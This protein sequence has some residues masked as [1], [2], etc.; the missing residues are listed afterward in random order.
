[1][2]PCPLI[3][4][5]RKGQVKDPGRGRAD[6]SALS[7]TLLPAASLVAWRGPCPGGTATPQN[8]PSIPQQHHPWLAREDQRSS[9]PGQEGDQR[10]QESHDLPQATLQHPVDRETL[11]LLGSPPPPPPLPLLPSFSFLSISPHLL[12]LPCHA[13]CLLVSLSLCVSLSRCGSFSNT[14]CSSSSL[15]LCGS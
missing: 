1:M 3:R 10:T 13:F 7:P 4:G 6:P 8:H 14:P 9:A 15:L 12:S 2:S 11:D 5:L